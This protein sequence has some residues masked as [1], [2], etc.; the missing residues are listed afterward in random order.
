M[1]RPARITVKLVS[2]AAGV[3]IIRAALPAVL[4]WLVNLGLRKTPGCR[5]RVRR[6]NLEFITPRL[7][8]QGFALATLN[9]GQPEHHFEVA[10]FLWVYYSGLIFYFGAEF[11]KVYADHYGSRKDIVHKKPTAVAT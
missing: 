11:T 7:V 6:V 2:G 9:G 10:S 3:L 4:T 1:N 5:G 8:I